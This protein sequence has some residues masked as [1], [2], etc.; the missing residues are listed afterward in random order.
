MHTVFP[1][2]KESS[3]SRCNTLENRGL[4]AVVEKCNFDELRIGLEYIRIMQYVFYICDIVR[5]IIL[6]E[7]ILNCPRVVRFIRKY[8]AV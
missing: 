4:S 8:I 6:S 7:I 5:E 2:V 1:L 3:S